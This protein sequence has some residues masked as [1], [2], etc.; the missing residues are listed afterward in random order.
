[1]LIQVC[2]SQMTQLSEVSNSNLCNPFAGR[3]LNQRGSIKWT[4]AQEISESSGPENTSCPDS[5]RQNL[6]VVAEAKP[7]SMLSPADADTLEKKCFHILRTV[8]GLERA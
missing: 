8:L 6:L 4:L 2:D 5:D 7:E 3:F 1:M